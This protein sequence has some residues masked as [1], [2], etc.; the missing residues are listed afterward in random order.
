MTKLSTSLLDLNS[1]SE[2]VEAQASRSKDIY[3]QV[4]D[5]SYDGMES[6]IVGGNRTR[7]SEW[8]MSQLCQKLGLPYTYMKNCDSVNPDLARRNYTEWKMRN[9]DKL[10]LVRTYANEVIGILSDKYTHFDNDKVLGLMDTTNLGDFKIV[11]HSIT[12][13][14][15]TLRVTEAEP[16]QDDLFCA[17]QLDN[18]QVGRYPLSVKFM[19]YKQICT[20]GLI[21]QHA[22]SNV[23]TKKHIGNFLIDIDNVKDTLKKIDTY[24]TVA[25]DMVVESMRDKLSAREVNRV[26]NTLLEK[27][28]LTPDRVESGEVDIMLDLYGRTRWGFVNILTELS[29][30]FS[31]D[32]RL[33]I[34]SYAGKLLA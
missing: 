15:M 6:I 2:R 8:A 22:S 24:R 17:V 20:N 25:K 14:R 9:S 34:E 27:R 30:Q 10:V 33:E 5:L 3:L 18:S 28:Y 26:V 13:E 32:K 7:V 16:F 23:L 11:G 31:L 1:A 4:G 21:L 29:Q 12:P 19:V